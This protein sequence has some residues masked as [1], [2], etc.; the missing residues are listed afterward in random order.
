MKFAKGKEWWLI[1]FGIIIFVGYTTLIYCYLTS[2][3]ITKTNSIVLGATGMLFV[4]LFLSVGQLT[5]VDTS[6]VS[7]KEK[8]IAVIIDFLWG[9]IN[10]M[11]LLAGIVFVIISSGIA[12]LLTIIF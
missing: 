7:V 10:I 1:I 8:V 6:S 4:D 9:L 11:R 2:I 3:G 12:K 5:A